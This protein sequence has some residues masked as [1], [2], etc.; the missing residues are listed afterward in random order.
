MSRGLTLT[1]GSI[2]IECRALVRH[3]RASD[4][5]SGLHLADGT[6]IGGSEQLAEYLQSSSVKA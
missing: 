2:R 5:A 1:A 4:T 3:G 6:L